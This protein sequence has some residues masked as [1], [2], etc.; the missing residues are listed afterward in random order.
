MRLFRANLINQ[1]NPSWMMRFLILVLCVGF[2]A[3]ASCKKNHNDSPPTPVV[4]PSSDKLIVSFS[5]S[6]SM[7]GD[8]VLQTDIT[9][10]TNNDT[11]TVVAPAKIDR[12]A[13]IPTITIS[14]KTISPASNV[15]QDFTS[16]VTYTVTA[17][18]GSTK[19]YIV[20]VIYRPTLFMTT[21]HVLFAMD[22]GSGEMIWST[23]IGIY[24]TGSATVGNGLVYVC[25]ENGLYAVHA[26]T[27]KIKWKQA[28]SL[29]FGNWV[30]QPTPLL[31][32]GVVYMGF[33]NG[34][35]YA[36]DAM[37][38]SIKWKTSNSGG[39]YCSPSLAN[40]MVYIGGL[41]EV[42]YAMDAE[43]GAIRWKRPLHGVIT[44][45]PLVINN[46]LYTGSLFTDSLYAIDAGTGVVLWTR[47]SNFFYSSPTMANGLLYGNNSGVF[48]FNLALKQWL[49]SKVES[50]GL[51]YNN[52]SSAFVYNG[53]AY[54]SSGDG[55]VYAY[56]AITGTKIWTAYGAGNFVGSPM[57]GAHVLYSAGT[58]TVNAI[59]PIT[60]TILWSKLR[61]NN[62]GIYSSACVVDANGTVYHPAISG[63]Q[64]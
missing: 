27:G 17:A 2:A 19:K 45:N 21:D 37:T 23:P 20:K 15:T 42:L 14:G 58:N 60:G 49:F 44:C 22:A 9:G 59:D 38:G 29:V 39:F 18:D 33:D 16:P 1:L 53:M 54:G 61:G 55:N 32:N 25:S 12:S 34:N 8:S 57:V 40:H 48:A 43:T 4:P 50:V 41:D 64:D 56:N 62:Q 10:S 26:G 35:M 36:M 13:L 5:L 31:N 11:I 7:N 28:G 30:P 52:R 47:W 63:E 24:V 46:V 3:L 51:T 6:R